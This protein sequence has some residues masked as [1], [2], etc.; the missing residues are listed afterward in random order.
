MTM[1]DDNERITSFGRFLRE[2]SLD[3]LP[4]V[5]NLISG[6]I[7]LVGPRPLPEKYRD[8]EFPST[9]EPLESLV[10]QGRLD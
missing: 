7:S 5:I 6:D 9:R 8:R 2:S 3:E 10:F 1:K 4:S